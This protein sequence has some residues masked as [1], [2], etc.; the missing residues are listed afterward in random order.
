MR[1]R[2]WKVILIVM[3][4]VV[5]ARPAYAVPVLSEVTVAL[6]PGGGERLSFKTNTPVTPRKAFAL[7]DPD[8]IVIDLPSVKAAGIALPNDYRGDL[9][10]AIRFGQFDPQTSRLVV[11]LK[12]P[13]A[14]VRTIPGKPF[15]VEIAP[16]ATASSSGG[17]PGATTAP[18][19][20][21]PPG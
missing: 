11:D 2:W 20:S 12:A 3:V 18:P 13:A 6:Q 16:A 14:V 1:E 9:I 8:R 10:R 5:A 21:R 7:A 4:C 19:R 15:T 17:T